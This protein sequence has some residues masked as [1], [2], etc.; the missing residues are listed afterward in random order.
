MI[1][2]A[3]GAYA[4]GLNVLDHAFEGLFSGPLVAGALGRDRVH[5]IGPR[6]FRPD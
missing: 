6:S 2:P 5:A 4:G 3:F 1:V